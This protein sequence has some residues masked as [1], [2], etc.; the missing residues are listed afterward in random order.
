[1]LRELVNE[2]FHYQLFFFTQKTC[3]YAVKALLKPLKAL[4]LSNIFSIL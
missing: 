1:M 4:K 3:D 2:I